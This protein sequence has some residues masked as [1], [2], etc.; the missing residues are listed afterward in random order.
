MARVKKNTVDYFPHP[1]NNGTRMYVMEQKYGDKGY[2][3]YYK[4]LEFLGRTENHFLDFSNT[5]DLLYF[6]ALIN[7]D[8]PKTIEMISTLAELGSIDRNL[9]LENRVVWCKEFLDSICGVYDKRGRKIPHKPVICDRN[10]A[11]PVQ[12]VTEMPQSRVEYNK[13][14]ESKVINVEKEFFNSPTYSEQILM[15]LK[16]DGFKYADKKWILKKQE[17]FILERKLDN[18]FDGRSLDDIKKYF[19]NWVKK[20]DK[21][22][23][24]LNVFVP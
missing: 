16:L 8:E 13:V 12:S 1:V 22:A 17:Q 10:T 15:M 9:W 6:S 20:Q 2:C 24:G 14:E 18:D 11:T 4:L 3:C 21:P 5:K 23:P 7:A 19:K